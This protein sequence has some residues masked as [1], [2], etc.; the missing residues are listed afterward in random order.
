MTPSIGH[1]MSR[2]RRFLQ[3]AALSAAGTAGSVAAALVL[4]KLATNTLPPADVTAWL[5]AVLVADGLNLAFNFGL[6]ASLPKLVAARDEDT[7]IPFIQGVLLGQARVSGAVLAVLLVA[8]A[9]LP[10]LGYP[11]RYSLLCAAAG[12][13]AFLG[14]FRDTLL[15]ILN[16]LHA[17]RAHAAAAL[18]FGIAQVVLPAAFVG[19]GGLGLSGLLLA[20]VLAQASCV[21][22]LAWSVLRGKPWNPEPSYGG[23]VRFSVPLYANS[24]LNYGFQRAD[25]F[26]VTAILGLPVAGLYEIAKRFPQLLS[27]SLNALLL[28]WLPSIAETVTAGRLKDAGRTLTEVL[29]VI[30]FLGQTIIVLAFPIREGLVLLLSAPAYAGAADAVIPLMVGIF[31][32]VQAGVFGQTLIALD[33]PAWV[34]AG[35]LAQVVLSLGAA[36]YL[37]PRMGIAGAG[38]GW[39]IGAGASMVLQA[40]GVR[41]A[42]VHPRAITRIPAFCIFIGSLALARKLDLPLLAPGLYLPLG[43]ALA[44]WNLR[45]RLSIKKAP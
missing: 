35:N 6:F 17:Y 23:A 40:A 38:Y 5:L 43:T 4:A 21:G 44:A 41:R 22:M 42:G 36:A 39:I 15:S 33:R 24:L 31:L 10:A 20:L 26:L 32:A 18:G 8:A 12:A 14:V 29:I 7:R 34:T 25:T 3:G 13:L 16:G 28:P 30:T 9:A 45:H 11:P 1:A 37:L 19:W 27:R 2:S